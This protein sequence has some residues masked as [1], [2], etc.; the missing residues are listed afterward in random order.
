MLI[1]FRRRRIVAQRLLAYSLLLVQPAVRRKGCQQPFNV[2]G[3]IA[4]TAEVDIDG[5]EAAA[6][7]V[8]LR[9]A[10]E[11]RFQL[12]AGLVRHAAIGQQQAVLRAGVAVARDE[13]Q[14][15][16]VVAQRRPEFL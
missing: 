13:L 5:D 4:V 2:V 14:I 6:Q 12:K 1:G 16:L 10:A 8:L 15:K 7:L 11:R 9:R 3:G